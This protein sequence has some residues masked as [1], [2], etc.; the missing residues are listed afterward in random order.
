MSW[1]DMADDA[2]AFDELLD[3]DEAEES[4]EPPEDFFEPRAEEYVENAPEFA[5]LRELVECG[6]EH[7]EKLAAEPARW[8]WQDYAPE[9]GVIV[10]AGKS[11]EGKSTLLFALLCARASSAGA[12][13]LCERRVELVPQCKRVLLIEGEHSSRSTARKLVKTCDF[14]G[15]PH[16]GLDKILSISRKSVIIGSERWQLIEQLVSLGVISDLAIDTL[17]RCS[18]VDADANDERAQVAVFDALTRAIERAPEPKPTVWILAHTRKA[19]AGAD[20]TASLDSVA[21]S[22]QRVGQADSVIGIRAMR[23]EGRVV[24]AQVSLLKAREE[25]EDYPGVCEF[26]LG[27]GPRRDDESSFERV[28]ELWQANP[29]VTNRE[30]AEELGIS[31]TLAGRHLKTLREA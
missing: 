22:L 8:V 30:A 19:A 9:G 15:L 20:E 14:L 10:L 27:D 17:A 29:D 5:G 4:W 25:P 11:G 21:G 13:E 16:A 1:E 28:R 2:G 7:Y 18:P 31:K 26:V 23:D 12:I 6:A 3:L 24:G